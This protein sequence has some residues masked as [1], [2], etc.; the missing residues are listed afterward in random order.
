[1]Q[2]KKNQTQ[3][4][5]LWEQVDDPNVDRLL[6]RVVELILNDKQEISPNVDFDTHPLK[7]LNEGVPVE[8]ANQSQPNE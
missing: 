4:A 5:I 3:L 7:G 6:R 2:A 1:M 8:N